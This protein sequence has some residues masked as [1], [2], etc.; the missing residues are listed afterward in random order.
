METLTLSDGTVLQNASAILSDNELFVY[1]NDTLFNSVFYQLSDKRRTQSIVYTM[2]NG[3]M[4]VFAG[5]TRLIALRD[6]GK[7]LIT[8]VLRK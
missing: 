6:E 8:A 1:I 3:E 5:F 4:V 2:V 7:G